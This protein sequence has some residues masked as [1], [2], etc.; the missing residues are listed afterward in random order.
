MMSAPSLPPLTI[1]S[2]DY[3]DL[4]LYAGMAKQKGDRNAEFMLAELRRA[5]LCDPG[6][7]PDDIVSTNCRVIYRL[8]EASKPTAHLLVHPRH[9]LWPDAE[10][11][12]M[13]PVGIALLGLRVGDTMPFVA[14]DDF[15]EH[16]VRVEGVG[17]RFL[18]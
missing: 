6:E 14:G 2:T 12:V 9:L 16:E 4:L 8:D 10:L 7:L 5:K 17:L 1:A 15:I 11:S 18:A 3:D 13:T